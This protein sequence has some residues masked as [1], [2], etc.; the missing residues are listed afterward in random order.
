[1]NRKVLLRNL[2]ILAIGWHVGAATGGQRQPYRLP[3]VDITQTVIWGATCQLPEGSGLSFGGQDQKADDGRPH[4]RVK[5]KGRW[6]AIHNELRAANPLQPVYEATVAI[7]DLHRGATAR[8]RFLNFEGLTDDE[9]MRRSREEVAHAL[10]R[11]AEG[12]GEVLEDLAKAV[13]ARDEYVAGHAR[14]AADHLEAVRREVSLLARALGNGI[15]PATIRQMAAVALRMERAAE[16]LD[17]EP[18]P[19]ALSPIVYDAK[20]GL[21]VLFG[22]D[23][24][25]YLTSDTWVFDPKGGRW[26]E[27]H[28]P[29]S[30]SPRANH[31]LVADGGGR[32]TLTGGYTYTSNTDYCGGQYVDCGDGPWTYDIQNNRW[33]GAGQAAA[34][35]GR[36]YRT[37]PF[38]PEFYL[39][40]PRPNAAAQQKRL[41]ELPQNRWVAMDPPKLPRLNRDWGTAVI[42]PDHDLILRFSGGHS[43]H[44]G[45][46]V[47]LYHLATNR[48]ELPFPVEFPLGQ[49]YANTRYPDGLN[50]N[51]R[52]WVTGHTYMSYDYSPAL[53]QMIFNGRTSHYYVYDPVVADWVGRGTKPAGMAYGGCFYDLNTCRTARGLVAWTKSGNLF[54]FDADRRKWVELELRGVALPGSSV[55]NS[56]VAYDSPRDRLLLVRKPYGQ[57]HRFDGQI[58]A[59]NLEML[60]VTTLSPKG[61]AG[62]AE[63]PFL[64]E[65]RYSRDDDLWLVGATLPAGTDGLRRTP[66]Y[67]C[68]GNRWVSL[69]ITGDDPSGERGRNVSLGLVYDAKRKRFWAV[70]TNSQVYTLK[71]DLNAADVQPLR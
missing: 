41:G 36:V 30:P 21:Y 52:P 65:I 1:M 12:L 64:R 51:R 9:Q 43:A 46:D 48:W 40:A 13:I 2:I 29:S 5:R 53:G 70:D 47:L 4:T 33:S 34:P 24:C 27:R 69:R 8:A 14:R 38:H 55:D 7:R 11:V 63:I 57:Q 25:D 61:M 59:V 6:V 32:V 31:K 62:A 16:L 68:A 28:P 67:D 44:G 56:T 15:T 58:Y 71:L 22:G 42:D 20:A 50:F 23:H 35:G 19:R 37:G 60:V 26:T 18:P 17:A 49:L 54:R 10:Q 66:A 45:S 3:D 39:D